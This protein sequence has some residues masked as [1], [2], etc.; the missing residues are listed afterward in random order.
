LAVV[1]EFVHGLGIPV[2]SLT[3]LADELFRLCGS[4]SWPYLSR[5]QIRLEA[6]QLALEHPDAAANLAHRSAV[7]IPLAPLVMR[8]GQALLGDDGDA[9]R[10]LP[11]PLTAQ[12]GGRP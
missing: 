9:Q 11:F 4:R 1:S 10:E 3:P 6:S 7:L 5:C 8:L 12:P 2:S